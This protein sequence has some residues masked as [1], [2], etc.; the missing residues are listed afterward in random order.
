M[1]LFGL[2][3]KWENANKNLA[4]SIRFS[5]HELGTC[6]GF[7]TRAQKFNSSDAAFFFGQSSVGVKFTIGE[8]SSNLAIITK[9]KDEHG[10]TLYELNV[11]LRPHVSTCNFAT[12][13]S[14][15]NHWFDELET[16]PDLLHQVSIASAPSLL[17]TRLG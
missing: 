11:P 17:R 4:E 5:D 10:I 8:Y 1:S 12:L 13:K 9:R 16:S 15:V 6:L 14:A 2:R 7:A 3:P